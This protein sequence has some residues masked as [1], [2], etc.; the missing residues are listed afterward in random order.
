MILVLG[1]TCILSTFADDTKLGRVADMPEGCAAIQRD[2]SRLHQW[3]DS[4][5]MKFKKEK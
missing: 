1:H 2:L 3:V 4:S 5:L